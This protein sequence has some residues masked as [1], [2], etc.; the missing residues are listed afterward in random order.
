M[1]LPPTLP[2]R[3]HH[4][5]AAEPGR[6]AL[7]EKR[8]GIWNQL[9][10]REYDDQV[11]RAAWALALAGI[12]PGDHVAILSDNRPEWLYVDLAAEA[13][14]ARSV[15]IYQTDSAPDIAYILSDCGARLVFCADQEQVDK[16]VACAADTPR[17]EGV[18]VFDPRGTRRIVDPRLR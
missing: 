4:F 8:L 10:F 6:I 14:G 15:G 13:I 17:V 3:V 9:T 11:R 5:A 16:L 2:G 1:S 18:V 12:R 7:R